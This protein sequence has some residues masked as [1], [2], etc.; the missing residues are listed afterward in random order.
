MVT[1]KRLTVVLLIG[2]LVVLLVMAHIGATTGGSDEFTGVCVYSSGSF[3]LLSDGRTTVGVYASLQEGRVYRAVGRMYNTTSGA[4]LRD[5]RIEPA[6]PDFPLSTVEGAYW[7]SSDLYILTPERVRLAVALPVEKGRIVRIE[8]IWYRNRFYPLRYRVLGFPGKPRESM[9]WVVEGTV[10]YNGSR[11]VIWNGSE[12]V[13]L[14]LPYGTSLEVGER[15]RVVGIVRFYSKLSLI[16]DSPDDVVVTGRAERVPV[17]EASIGDIAVGNCTV[18]AAGR[19]LKLDCTGLR[20]HNFRARVGDRIHFEAVRRRS[21][22]HCLKCEVIEPREGLPNGIC[23]F[24]DG[25]FARIAGWVEW[26]RV[27]RN[28]F[29]LA[30]VTNGDCWVLLKLRKSLNVSLEANEPVTAY[31]F[32]TTYRNMPAFEVAS[33]DD[34]CSGNC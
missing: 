31:G 15:V 12:E 22:L 27:Y 7:P 3:S 33:G 17:S 4:R 19:S 16:V 29:G 34:L 20:L 21:S 18:I 11:T 26:L 2:S 25:A 23:S 5:A 6:E 14:Y 1:N 9:P 10:I 30:N 28:G 24:S 13:V 8:G 32:F